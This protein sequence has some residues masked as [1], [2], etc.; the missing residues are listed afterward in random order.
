MSITRWDPFQNLATLQDQVNRLFENPLAGRRAESS[1]LTAW[2]P[3]VDIYETENEL[4]IKAD[5][6]DI[7]EKDLDV[8][9]ENNMLTIRGERK[10]EQK[11]NEDN[12]LRIER[13]YGSFG[14]SFSLP[15]TVDTESIQA[16][17]KNGA[18]TVE[19]PKRAESKPRQVK[20]NVTANGN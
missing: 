11:V 19:L 13:T 4:V 20:V 10:F 16:E 3:A 15:T 6:P 7:N 8:R 14:R 2:A 9:V 12:Y 5:L 18:L 1:N 17:Y